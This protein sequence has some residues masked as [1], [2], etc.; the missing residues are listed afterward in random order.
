[1]SMMFN[2][3]YL[4]CSAGYGEVMNGTVLPRLKEKERQVTVAGYEGR[5][6]YCVAYDADQPAGTVVIVHGFTENALKYA[7]LIWSLLHLHFSVIAYDQRGHGRSW[8]EEGLPDGR[9]A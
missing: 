3:D 8:R 4:V 6:L 5:P 2:E 1:M 7:E 9:C